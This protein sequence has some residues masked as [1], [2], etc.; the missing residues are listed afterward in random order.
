MNLSPKGG[1]GGGESQREFAANIL[2]GFKMRQVICQ[3]RKVRV[4][5]TDATKKCR[6]IRRLVTWKKCIEKILK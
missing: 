3:C 6:F 2:N 5:K 1:G 4:K